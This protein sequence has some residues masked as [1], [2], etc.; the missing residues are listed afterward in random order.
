M[1]KKNTAVTGF[2]IGH[3]IQTAD[4]AAKTTGTP[5]CKRL[6]DGTAGT[7]ANAASY[8]AT[9]GV[10][11]ID[12]AAG[13]MN[14]DMVGLVFTLADCIPISYAIRTT[15]KLVSDLNDSA[16]AGGAVASVTGDVGGKVLGGGASSI[17]G[18]GVRAVDASGDALATA[19]TAA[20]ILE[21]TGTTLPAAIADV[22]TVAEFE[23]R[24]LPAASYFDPAADTVVNVT[25]VATVTGN[26]GGN[27]TGSVGSVAAGGITAASI[28]DNA[29]DAAALS[30]DAVDAILDEIVEGSV[31]MRQL[32]RGFAAVLLGKSAN[33]G[34]DYRDLADTKTRVDSTLDGSGNRTAV[35]LDL[36]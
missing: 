11:K 24:T 2:P 10:W 4:G 27:V 31:T 28:A 23:A 1:F 20:A 25:N 33:S 12:L 22:P 29:I 35:T 32:L 7:L 14:G 9:A 26:V 16:Y 5:T 18:T 3:F 21:D 8:D 13:D 19:A 15:T 34:A 6:L 17:T 36:T 30:D